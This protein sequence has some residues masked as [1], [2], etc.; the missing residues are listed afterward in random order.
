MSKELQDALALLPV[1]TAAE[2][3]VV[4]E[5]A[6][7]LGLG[8]TAVRS[9]AEQVCHLLAALLGKA[10]PPYSVICKMRDYKQF[11]EGARV[12]FAYIAERPELRDHRQRRQVELAL[13]RC[14]TEYGNG[15]GLRS[16]AWGLKHIG[17]VVEA[18]YPGYADSGVL[19][20]VLCQ[21][22]ESD[23]K[24]KEEPAC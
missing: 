18:N 21:K 1:L 24:F 3:K 8:D 22:P 20:S 9:Q 14:V 12:F 16:V 15:I 23:K 13:L 7:L 2:R 6:T 10:W 4:A 5:R 11:V 17:E 19:W